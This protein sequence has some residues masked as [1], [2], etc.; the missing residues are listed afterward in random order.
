MSEVCKKKNAP[1]LNFGFFEPLVIHGKKCSGYSSGGNIF[2]PS[3]SKGY[4]LC[5][6][7]GVPYNRTNESGNQHVIAHVQMD[8][9]LKL[10]SI[11]KITL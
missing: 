4:V 1:K 3:Y 6:L 7:F 9:C 8:V 11:L 5:T 10:L 2:S